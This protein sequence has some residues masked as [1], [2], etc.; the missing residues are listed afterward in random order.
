MFNQIL[1]SAVSFLK[2][3]SNCN[4]SM[5]KSLH[6][7]ILYDFL[8]FTDCLINNLFVS[9]NN[10]NWWLCSS[11]FTIADVSLTILLE[12]LNQ[13]G[14]EKR[15]WLNNKRPHVEKYY[16]RVK[17]RSSYKKTIPSTFKHLQMLMLH[18][19]P[20]FIGIGLL[21]AVSI[22]IGGYFLIKRIL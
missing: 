19:K 3:Y 12:R 2:A 18:Q 11:Q 22:V 16:Q 5:I 7:L 17:Q 13:L 20:L 14:F 6:F 4:K 8:F 9:D 15:F 21:T 10:K 1:Q